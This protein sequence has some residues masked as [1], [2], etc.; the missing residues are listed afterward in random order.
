MKGKTSPT[1]RIRAT[2][3]AATT[4]NLPPSGGRIP[5]NVWSPVPLCTERFAQIYKVAKGRLSAD[6]F[7]RQ[8]ET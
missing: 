3:T 4:R 7:G 6:L 5:F 1:S 8:A 2:A